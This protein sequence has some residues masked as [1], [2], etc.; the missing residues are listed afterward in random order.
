MKISIIR[1]LYYCNDAP[2][3]AGTFSRGKGQG[4]ARWGARCPGWSRTLSTGAD[5]SNTGS[6][7]KQDDRTRGSGSWSRDKESVG[8]ETCRPVWLPQQARDQLL[9]PYRLLAKPAW[10]PKDWS[11]LPSETVGAPK[12]EIVRSSWFFTVLENFTYLSRCKI[13]WIIVLEWVLLTK[14]DPGTFCN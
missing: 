5:S 2:R 12:M 3:G 7:C 4:L 9:L 11:A 10:E 13:P 1:V 6:P 14:P 8:L